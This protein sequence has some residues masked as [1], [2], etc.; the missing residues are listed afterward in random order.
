MRVTVRL[1]VTNTEWARIV[2]G[3]TRAG[4]NVEDYIAIAALSADP[5]DIEE[6][7]A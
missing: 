3:A 5:D 2:D 6:V 4:L 1:E 7:A